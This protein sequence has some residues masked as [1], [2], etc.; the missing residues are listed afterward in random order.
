MPDSKVQCKEKINLTVML[1]TI[2][3]LTTCVV[4][5]ILLQCVEK[6]G[7]TKKGCGSYLV[8]LKR[9]VVAIL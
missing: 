3:F 8:G 7:L 6:C 1:R 5:I 4:I 9:G 2:C